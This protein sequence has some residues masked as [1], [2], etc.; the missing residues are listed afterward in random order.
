[1][2][3]VAAIGAE[4]GLASEE[5]ADDGEAG[6][7]RGIESAIRG[8]VMPRMVADFWLQRTP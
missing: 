5:T 1:V 3:D 4:D 6:I 8:A 7:K 2:V